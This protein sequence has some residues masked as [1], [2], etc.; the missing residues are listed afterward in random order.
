L[1]APASPPTP[2][3][4]APRGLRTRVGLVL[5]LI[6][7]LGAYVRGLPRD[8]SYAAGSAVLTDGDSYYHLRRVEQTLARGGALPMFDPELAH[9][10]GMALQWHGGYDLPLAGVIALLCGTAPARSCLEQTAA[11]STPVIG[12]AGILLVYALGAATAGPAVGLLAALSFAIHP[13]SAGSAQL[14]S[15]DHHVLEPLLPAL[16]LLLLA[17]RRVWLAALAC[18]W[19]L[20][21]VPSALAPILATAVAALGAQLVLR[22]A[23]V[24]ARATLG[25]DTDAAAVA[26]APLDVA[27]M[28]TLTAAFAIPL[29]LTSPFAARFDVNGLSLLHLCVLA[30]AAALS[31]GIE[32]A[33]RISL[34][35]TLRALG[36]ALAIVAGVCFVLWPTLSRF[37]GSAGLWGEVA[38]LRSLA[39]GF[40]GYAI[41]TLVS[42]GLCAYAVLRARALDAP[43][44]ALLAL[45]Q[46][47]TFLPGVFQMRYLMPASAP[48]AV[49]LA[50]ALADGSAALRTRMRHERPRAQALAALVS[51]S[52]LV[53]AL[54]PALQ[55]VRAKPAP[56]WPNALIRVLARGRAAVAVHGRGAL[57]ADWRFGHHGLYFAGLPVV[58][59]PFM[60]VGRELRG[61][62]DPNVAARRALLSVTPEDLLASIDALDCR[63]LLLSEPFDVAQSARTLGLTPPAKVA[64]R[65]LLDGTRPTPAG[66]QLL[67]HEPTA[68]LYV[69]VMAP[70]RAPTP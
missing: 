23:P 63:Y 25:L 42:L 14:G 21:A 9:P 1:T 24:R 62:P 64:A 41:C 56:E 49:M 59:S 50:F 36:V 69:R 45:L 38:Q 12:T 4:A 44:L 13:W 40:T 33:L 60:W 66:L 70:S 31:Y 43:L 28:L 32:R 16:W 51:L 47:L 58:A 55:T 8:V 68:R 29:V 35:A 61:R 17:R 18:A 2:D 7:L 10:H 53:L 27:P 11:R 57:L 52:V 34:I 30:L 39:L 15:V 6:L 46:P 20:A 5:C 19:A 65:E 37:S 54:L 3:A 67:A 48:F 22:T 26:A